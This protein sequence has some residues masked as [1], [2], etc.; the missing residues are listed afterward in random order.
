MK[1]LSGSLCFLASLVISVPAWAHVV[2]VDPAPRTSSDALKAG[3]C[4]AIPRTSSASRY[5]PGQTVTV[6][7]TETVEHPGDFRI[8]FS[9]AGDE[10]FDDASQILLDDIKDISGTAPHAYEAQVKLPDVTC[11]A[12]TLQ[13]RQFMKG[14]AQPYYYS[15]ADIALAVDAGGADDG[16]GGGGSDGS[17]IYP[18][19]DNT[20]EERD[21][22]YCQIGGPAASAPG[23]SLWMT[24]VLFGIV[25]RWRN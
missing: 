24:L 23:F 25:R 14:S 12:C 17:G 6:R 8:S 20:Y 21:T 13:L 3:P 19:G 22:G 10:G 16:G 7:W 11:S 9:P 15:C 2:L 1:L 18:G 5:R 4:G